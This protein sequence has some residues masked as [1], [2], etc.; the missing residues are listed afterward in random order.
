MYDVAKGLA[1]NGHE[2]TV[3]AINT[4]KHF[5]KEQVL[6]S[7]ENITLKTVFVDTKISPLGA[8]LNLFKSIPYNIERFYSSEFDDAIME[9]LL[10][11][12][13]DIIQF[14][15]TFVAVYIDLVKEWVQEDATKPTKI[16]LRVH[17]LE[18]RIWKR[19]SEQAF[20][21]KKWYFNY[22]SKGIKRFEKTYFEKFDALASISSM[23]TAQMLEEG[24]HTKIET[25]PAGV[26]LTRFSKDQTT[27]SPI[28]NSLFI[29][30]ALNWMPNLEAVHWFV[31]QVMPKLI[32]KNP[33]VQ[34]HL[35]GKDTPAEIEA[36]ASDHIKVHGFVDSA[37][38]FMGKYQLMLVPLLSGGG[39]RIKIIEGMAMGK[40]IISSSVGAEGINYEDEKDIFIQNTPEEW[41]ECIVTLLQNPNSI[42]QA[43]KA[44]FLKGKTYDN[45]V[46]IK[47][48]EKLYQ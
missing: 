7:I 21:F 43:E 5:Q 10:E 9:L 39:M 4:P 36:L 13:F 48:F 31:D 12:S 25:V 29:L 8:F 28:P 11:E 38:E 6:D 26:D 41:V 19:L 16:I 44:A 30:S 37:A 17:N 20:G 47:Q 14:E 40:C 24:Y 2:V 23:E 42:K 33:D 22:L 35:A 34:L 32:E 1:E 3:L 45:K 27:S 18:Y 15:G 46:V